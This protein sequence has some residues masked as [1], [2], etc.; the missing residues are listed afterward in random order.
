MPPQPHFSVAIGDVAERK[1]E[2]NQSEGCRPKVLI[3]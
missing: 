2:Q 1:D 3:C